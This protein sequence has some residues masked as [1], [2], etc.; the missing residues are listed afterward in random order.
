MI[1]MYSSL[2]KYLKSSDIGA[3][4]ELDFIDVTKDGI[5]NYP[6]A[7][8]ILRKGYAIPLI[9]INGVVSY[10]GGIPYEKV[11]NEVKNAYLLEGEPINNM[12]CPV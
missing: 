5:E 3:A 6:A 8:N 11:Y 2:V 7:L 4:I 12:D 9:A 10:Y 1:K